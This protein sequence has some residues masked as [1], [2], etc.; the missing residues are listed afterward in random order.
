MAEQTGNANRIDLS[1]LEF[2]VNALFIGGVIFVYQSGYDFLYK[3]GLAL[4]VLGFVGMLAGLILKGA[5]WHN[6]IERIVLVGMMVGVLGMF[7][8]WNISL[9]ENGFYI[10]GLATL[11]FI[12]ISHIPAPP[13]D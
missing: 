7:Q 11:G 6:I 9:Y 2:G 12:I 3:L 5:N 4:L 13:E 1:L 10:L 8:S